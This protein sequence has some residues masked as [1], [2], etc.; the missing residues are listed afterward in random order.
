MG[1]RSERVDD[2]LE[3]RSKCLRKLRDLGVGHRPV[4][5]VSHMIETGW[6]I[7]IA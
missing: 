6:A 7:P 2:P 3:V 4:P 5:M 1:R